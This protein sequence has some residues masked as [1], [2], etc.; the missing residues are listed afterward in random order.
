MDIGKH[1]AFITVESEIPEAG[2]AGKPVKSYPNIRRF[3]ARHDNGCHSILS[4]ERREPRRIV[5][6]FWNMRGAFRRFVGSK[7]PRNILPPTTS[8]IRLRMALERISFEEA[9]QREVKSRAEWA[10]R[11]EDGWRCGCISG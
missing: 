9:C 3:I 2:K 5:R 11:V 10:A 1:R 8:S 6:L 7:P 4:Y